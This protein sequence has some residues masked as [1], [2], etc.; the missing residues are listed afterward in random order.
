MTQNLAKLVITLLEEPLQ[1]WGLDFIGPIKLAS[2]MLSNQYILVAIDYTKKWVEVQ[3]LCTNII[4]V[5][6]KSLYKHI[7]T[8][9]GCPLTIVTDQGTRFTNDVI[10]YLI[11]H[12]ILRHTSS[13]VYYPPR[14]GQAKSTNK[15]FRT[16]LTKLVNENRND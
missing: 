13:T 9:F 3:T 12:F 15:V 5:I 4:V 16:L 8:R 10:R 6:A 14:N 1:K 11:D 7:V 2:R